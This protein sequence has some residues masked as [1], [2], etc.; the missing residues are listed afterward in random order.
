MSDHILPSAGILP[1]ALHKLC[2]TFPPPPDREIHRDHHLETFERVAQ[3][4]DLLVLEGD[5][6]TGKTTLFSQFAKRYPKRAISSFVAHVRRYRYDAEALR[7]DYAAQILSIVDPRKSLSHEHVRDG[8]LQSLIQRLKRT[9]GNRTY[10]FLL[11]GLTDIPDPVMRTEVALLLP[12]GY[13]FPVIISG[14]A[15]L[16]PSEIRDSGRTKTTQAVNFSFAEAQEYLSDLG[17][18]DDQIRHVY[19]NCGTGLPANLASVRRSLLAGV[20]LARLRGRN[21]NDLYEQEWTHT[22]TDDLAQRIVAIVAHS[23]HQ[24]TVSAL[25]DLLS[26]ADDVVAD[27]LRAIPFLQ[28]DH[29]TSYVSF[30]SPSLSAFASDKLSDARTTVINDLADHLFDRGTIDVPDATDSLPTYLQE[31]GRLDEVIS[32]LS[33]D[34][35]ARVLERTESFLP[36]RRQ[37]Q[38]G[39]DAAAQLHKDGELVRFGLE[40]SAIREIE[41]ALVSRSEIEAL[42]ATDQVASA[43]SLA[44]NCPLREDRLHLLGVIARCERERD[45]HVNDDIIE[46]IRQ[47]HSQIDPTSLG[48]KAIDI[49]ADLFPSCPDLAFDLIEHSSSSDGDENELDVA[50]VR[51][52]IATAVR[53]TTPR[54]AQDDLETI[55][56]R[57]KNPRL[58]G[59]TSAL[60][61]RVQSANELIAE[62]ASLAT[63]SDRLY[64]LRK[65]TTEHPARDDAPDVAEY[66][67]RTVVEATDYAPNPRVFR[68]LST[69]LLHVTDSIRARSL[70]RLFDGQRMTVDDH[71]PTEEVIRL[72]LNLATAE[73]TY[74]IDA[75]SNRL[76][77]VYLRVDELKDLST[78]ASCLAWLL[79]TLRSVDSAGVIEKKERLTSLSSSELDKAVAGLLDETAEQVDVT[80]RVIVALASL[81]FSRSVSVAEKL[82]TAARREEALLI[83][84]DAALEADSNRVDLARVRDLCERL[85]MSDSRDHVAA[86]VAEYLGGR[87]SRGPDPIVESGFQLFQDLFF[88]VTDRVERCR[89]LCLLYVLAARGSYKPGEGT[90]LKMSEEIRTALEELEPGS[91]RIDAGFRVARSFA[92][93]FPTEAK[94]YL[95]N[96]EAERN[97]TALSSFS[98]E[99]TFQACLRLALRAF[100]GQLGHG[101]DTKDDISRIGRL[102]DRLPSTALRVSLWGELS[103]HLFLQKHTDDGNRVVTQ[104]V[105]PLL[106]SMSDGPTKTSTIVAISPALYRNHKTTALELFDRIE[107]H[108]QDTALMTCAEFILEKHIPSDPFESHEAGYDIT[109]QD[110]VDVTEIASEIRRDTMVYTLIVAL[111]DTLSALRISNRFSRQQMADLIRRMEDLASTTFPDQDNIRHDGYVVASEAQLLRVTRGTTQSWREVMKRAESIPNSSDRAL[112]LGMIGQ[113]MPAR[114]TPLRELAFE[115]AMRVTETIPCHYDR[116][117]RLNDL[118]G[119]MALKSADL[120]RKCLSDAIKGFQGAEDGTDAHVFRSLVDTAF[121]IDPDFAGSLVSLADDD[122]ARGMQG[123]E[124]NRR[125]ETLRAKKAIIDGPE[126]WDQF[127]AGKQDIARS[128]WLALGSLNAGRA[129]TAA[130]DQLRPALRAAGRHPLREG[131]PILAWVI[132]NAVRRFA[133]SHQSRASVRLILDGAIRAT[134]FAELAG[135]NASISIR[136]GA[137]SVATPASDDS[138]VV[139][140]GERDHAEEFLRTWLATSTPGRLYVCDQYF[141]P[142]EL[143]LLMLVQSVIP[144]IDIW[145]LTSRHCHDQRRIGSL[146]E[147]Y[148]AGWRTIS[149]QQPPRV[150]IVVVGL[151]ESRKSPI[152]DRYILSE[153]GG[154]YLGTSWNSLGSSQDSTMKLLSVTEASDLFKRVGQFLIERRREYRE[155]RLLYEM[156]TL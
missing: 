94:R 129:T 74:D 88:R 115:Q 26:V 131:F 95:D 12:I 135:T 13:G 101:Y 72:L 59:F 83:A 73:A 93:L 104:H 18:S 49:A 134:E 84:I 113:A 55:R 133:G 146:Y 108:Q 46:Q 10:Y 82:N 118:A 102:I 141:G 137:S 33:P 100:G 87:A 4:V 31:S 40:S 38:I 15:R 85:H 6:G 147:A 76:V 96:A 155:E 39:I 51:L 143:D 62:V 80:R 106:S 75:C 153:Q 89:V 154:I 27:R 63:A 86:A 32:F 138:I 126:S 36:L 25:S 7:R 140:R 69:P 48:D 145:V 142:T 139:Q 1:V 107:K 152:H 47:L 122:P 3:T 19:Q 81:D 58:R 11:D 79:S 52:S 110:A 103:M 16:L 21:L 112:V 53:Q 109:Y 70:V 123:H 50:Y 98:S 78:K 111:A 127:E 8:M 114:E 125:L 119:M 91:P 37:L 23:R 66:G 14:E 34:Y 64:I 124:M 20:P 92:D 42:V 99:W 67:L 121:K 35:F 136:R 2:T 56:K 9:H 28:L 148:S 24:L 54:S 90:Q 150:E 22:V 130:M 5:Q 30:V 60:S 132:E 105:T 65:W 68:E 120:A 156:V 61:S 116:L 44:A 57:I 17:V 149:D 71:G 41:T 29:D 97:R 117:G 144:D 128:A 45:T 77:E 43:L 151:E